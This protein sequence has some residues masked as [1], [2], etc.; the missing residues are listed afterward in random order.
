[1]E[2]KRTEGGMERKERGCFICLKWD[3]GRGVEGALFL[4]REPELKK[5][6]GQKKKKKKNLNGK[7]RCG[8]HAGDTPLE[9]ENK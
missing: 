1:M 6:Q 3:W 5:Q 2:E 9:S 7:T 8:W 4:W